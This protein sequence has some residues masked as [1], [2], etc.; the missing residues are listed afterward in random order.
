M[1]SN[2]PGTI[3]NRNQFRRTAIALAF[4]GASVT[5]V[6]ACDL[7]SVYSSAQASGELGRG[8]QVGLAEQFTHFGTLQ[9]DGDE[10]P[11]EANQ[12]LDSSVTQVFAGWNFLNNAGVQLNVPIIH[13]SFS[14]PE[15]FETDNGTESGLGDIALT[16]HYQFVLRDKEDSTIRLSLLGGIKL[17]T[18]SSDRLQEELSEEEVPGAPESGIHGHD[19]ALGSGSVDGLMGASIFA[20]QNRWFL[21]ANVQYAIRSEGDFGYQFAD[22]LQWEGG[23]G[24]LAVF[25]EDWTLSV[26]ANFSGEHKDQ[27]TFE[28]VTAEDTGID[29]IFVGPYFRLTWHEKLSADLG[30]DVPI[31]IDN[32]ALQLVPDYRIRAAFGWR[33]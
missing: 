20:R 24:Y 15:G 27:D 31:H 5:P 30:V 29:S 16:G 4:A 25:N 22:D 33:L 10:V 13:R 17:P 2:T 3:L 6:S 14:R 23:P 19:L 9:L 32:T 8:F 1:N 11:D 26:Q 21:G 7:C 18:G 12:H 28:G